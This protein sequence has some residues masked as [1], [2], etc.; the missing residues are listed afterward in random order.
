MLFNTMEIQKHET[1]NVR[2]S[3]VFTYRNHRK[4]IKQVHFMSYVKV[5]G[6]FSNGLLFFCCLG[7]D[8]LFPKIPVTSLVGNQQLTPILPAGN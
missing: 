8:E 5:K 2:I 4:W 1:D 3:A 7:G 6:L